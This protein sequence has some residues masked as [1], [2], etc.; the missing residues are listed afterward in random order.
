[1]HALLNLGLDHRDLRFDAIEVDR[2]TH[3][4]I[5]L[6]QVFGVTE[7]G[8][9]HLA[10]ARQ[11]RAVLQVMRT[12]LGDFH[13]ITV[14]VDAIRVAVVLEALAHAFRVFGLEQAHSVGVVA[15]EVP[16]L[17]VAD[18]RQQLD[19]L[20]PCGVITL[21][22]SFVQRLD[23]G[24]GYGDITLQSRLGIAEQAFAG[25]LDL[26]AGLALQDKQRGQTDDQREE[27]HRQDGKGQDFSLQAHAHDV[28]SF[29]FVGVGKGFNGTRT[30]NCR[31]TACRRLR[32]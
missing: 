3:R 8:H 29:D 22:S 28:H 31:S 27:Q 23:R 11:R 32:P 21:S 20:G 5:P 24:H 10:I 12:F 16:V 2:R 30:K 26:L 7:F 13:Q 25:F 14:D 9:Q 17:A 19:R 1:M 4:H 18:A 15:E 6:R